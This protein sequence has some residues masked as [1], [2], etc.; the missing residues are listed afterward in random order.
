MSD[1]TSRIRNQRIATFQSSL[2]NDLNNSQKRAIIAALFVM[3]GSK[4]STSEKEIDFIELI[5]SLLDI[6]MTSSY[7]TTMIEEEEITKALNTLDRAKKEWLLT[8]LHT[9]T[10]VDGKI[11]EIESIFLIGFASDMGISRSELN[12]LIRNIENRI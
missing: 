1:L 9:L 8:A 7:F 5:A 11:E 12:T 4:E 2:R 10:M 6:D 3:I